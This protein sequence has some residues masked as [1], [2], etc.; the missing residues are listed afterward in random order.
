MW[1][2]CRFVCD[3]QVDLEELME[4][5]HPQGIRESELKAKMQNR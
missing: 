5:L 3:T 2:G 4:S 1:T